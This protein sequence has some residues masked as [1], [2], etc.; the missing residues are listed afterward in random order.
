[1]AED[2]QRVDKWL[3]HARIARSR[4]LAQ[5]LVGAG[6]LRINRRKVLEPSHVVRAGDTLTITRERD[7]LVIRIEG[8]AA[9]RGPFA[10]ARLL[11]TDLRGGGEGEP[12][13][14]G[15]DGENAS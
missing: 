3:F 11:Y 13:P 10:Q 5:K 2:A 15:A 8:I 12:P 4:T 9:R 6:H 7:V 14:D 1:M